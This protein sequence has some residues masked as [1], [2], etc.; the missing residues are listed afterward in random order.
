MSG[1]SE[2]TE[3][4]PDHLPAFESNQNTAKGYGFYKSSEE[5]GLGKPVEVPTM[6]PFVSLQ[7]MIKT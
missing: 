6:P 4:R 3:L 7:W 1:G 2:A 5:A